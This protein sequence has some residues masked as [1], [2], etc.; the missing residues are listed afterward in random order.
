MYAIENS[1][2]PVE[3]ENHDL[4]QTTALSKKKKNIVKKN[5]DRQRK[6]EE[7]KSSSIRRAECPVKGRQYTA[8]CF[9]INL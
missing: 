2:Q 7:A 4:I 5:L 8:L 6:E 3:N 1:T 9:E